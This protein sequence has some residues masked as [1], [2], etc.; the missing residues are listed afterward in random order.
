MTL[1]KREWIDVL[2]GSDPRQNG[3]AS[4]REKCIVW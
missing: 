4:T 3:H 2:S 1:N